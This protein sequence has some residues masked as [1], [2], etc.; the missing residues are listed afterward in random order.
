M[1]DQVG[2]GKTAITLGL[3]DSAPKPPSQTPHHQGGKPSRQTSRPSLMQPNEH[4]TQPSIEHVN[5]KEWMKHLSLRESRRPR[6]LLQ[7]SARQLLHMRP[8]VLLSQLMLL[9]PLL[10]LGHLVPR[11]LLLMPLLGCVLQLFHLE[12]G[13]GLLC[14][15]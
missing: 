8:L 2:Y 3:V 12:V 5:S 11:L 1:A 15:S 4:S 9:S 13:V 6:R 14:N 7:S 10:N